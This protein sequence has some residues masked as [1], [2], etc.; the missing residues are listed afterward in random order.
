MELGFP[1]V[2]VAIVK[3]AVIAVAVHVAVCVE[4]RRRG[5]EGVGGREWRGGRGEW[6]GEGG[7]VWTI[8]VEVLFLMLLL[9]LR[10]VV[11]RQG[12]LLRRK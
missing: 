7:L 10:G 1:V 8:V 4:C 12:D 9:S 5:G 11:R 3:V 6:I 2:T